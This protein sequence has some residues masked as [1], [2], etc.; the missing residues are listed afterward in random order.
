MFM[1]VKLLCWI[2]LN[3]GLM[4]IMVYSKIFSGLRDYIK[5]LSTKKFVGPI[6]LFITEIL[7]C[8]MCFSTW[9]GFFTGLVIFSPTYELFGFTRY[10]S[11]FFDGIISSGAVWALN[12]YI[13]WYEKK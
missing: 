8:P 12:S 6:F 9:G 11:W 2:L 10:G 7:S 3:Y 13:E 4:N 1:L 5:E